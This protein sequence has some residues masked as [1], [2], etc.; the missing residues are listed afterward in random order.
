MK[1]FSKFRTI[2]AAICAAVVVFD[3]LGL[4]INV[5]IEPPVIPMDGY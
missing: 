2:F 4:P 5:T 3:V 1:P